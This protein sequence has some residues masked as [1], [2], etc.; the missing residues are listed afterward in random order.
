MVSDDTEHAVMTALSLHEAVGDGALF[1]RALA[2]RLG[3]WL[4]AIPPATGKATAVSIIKR[5][6][7]GRAAKSAG[8]GPAMRSPII[9]VFYA[10]KPD[11][12]EEFSRASCALTHDDVKA[13]QGS[14]AVALAASRAAASGVAGLNPQGILDFIRER[15]REPE[16]A[17]RLDAAAEHLEKR[18]E[19]GDFAFSLGLGNGVSAYIL[20]TVPA[21]LYCWL[22]YP[23][24]YR[25][26][27]ESAVRLGGD[28]DT[29]AAITGALCGAGTGVGG[30]PE[31]WLSGVIERPRSIAWMRDLAAALATGSRVPPYLW[32]ALPIRN[33]FFLG[34][35][36]AH[37]FRRLLPPY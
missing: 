18:A 24:D 3:W 6:L 33:L 21:A 25:A 15:I 10:N 5:P 7:F 16:L 13:E 8:N 9:G 12:V 26:A 31:E 11:C 27:V 32:P 34:I 28:T 30:M 36:L 22:R 14:L 1:A 20:D 35:V 2:R 23:R 17:R 19:P 4:L 29:V 37:G